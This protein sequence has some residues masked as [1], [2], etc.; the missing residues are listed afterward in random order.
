[1]T[2]ALIMSKVILAPMVRGSEL[3]F[4]TLVRRNGIHQC[5]SP[6]LRANEVVKAHQ[7]YKEAIRTTSTREQESNSNANACPR[8]SKTTTTTTTT[9]VRLDPILSQITHEDGKLLLTDILLDQY[10]L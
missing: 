9:L 5:Y 7:V 10:R 8:R 1:M 3:A 6:M 4:R 2:T